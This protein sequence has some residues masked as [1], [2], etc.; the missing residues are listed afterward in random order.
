MSP[1]TSGGALTPN[2]FSK[3]LSPFSPI[4]DNFEEQRFNT[5]SKK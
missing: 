5:N 3:E 4:S 1:S 2:R